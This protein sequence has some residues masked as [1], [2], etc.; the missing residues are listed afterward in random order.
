MTPLADV[1]DW[2][3]LLEVVWSASLAGLGVTIA[4]GFGI[5]GISRAYDFSRDGHTGWAAAFGALGVVGLATV[6]AAVIF[7]ITVM[8]HD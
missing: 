3:A 2:D 1:V 8:V 5:V 4:F 7:G 6:A